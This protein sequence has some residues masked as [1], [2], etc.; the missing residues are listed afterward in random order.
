MKKKLLIALLVFLGLVLLVAAGV[1][2][3]ILAGWIDNPFAEEEQEEGSVG[4]LRAPDTGEEPVFEMALP[5]GQ[6][7]SVRFDPS[8]GTPAWINGPFD[9]PAGV[10]PKDAAYAFFEKN[11]DIYGMT[12]PAEEL[13]LLSEGKDELGMSHVSLSQQYKGIPVFGSEL[14]VHVSAAN[15]IMAVNGS[16]FPNIDLSVEPTIDSGA[17]VEAA[18]R[19][20]EGVNL[21]KREGEEPQLVVVS[22]VGREAALSWKMTLLAEDSPAILVVFVDAHS[23]EVVFQYDDVKSVVKILSAENGSCD[24]SLDNL[25]MVYQSGQSDPPKNDIERD[26]FQNMEKVYQYFNNTH[27][28]NSY[29]GNGASVEAVVNCTFSGGPNAVWSGTEKKFIYDNG[30]R[31]G[32]KIAYGQSLDIVAH[33][34]T[35]AVTENT[36]G[37][38]YIFQSGA[39][40]ESYSDVFAAM[41]DRDDWE[42]GEDTGEVM[43]SMS[44]PAQHSQPAHMKDLNY[45]KAAECFNYKVILGFTRNDW[46]GVHSNS[47]IPNKAAYLTVTKLEEKGKKLNDT[48]YGRKVVEKIWYRALTSYLTPSSQFHD[49]RSASEVAAID[50]YGEGSDELKAVEE[51][52]SEVGIGTKGPT[53]NWARIKIKHDSPTAWFGMEKKVKVSVGVG[54]PS[55]PDWSTE[56]ASGNKGVFTEDGVY[57]DISEASDHLPPD[58]KHRWFL[59]VQDVK[60]DKKTASI[61][62]FGVIHDDLFYSTEDVPGTVTDK[63]ELTLFIPSK[64]KSGGGGTN[65]VKEETRAGAS[66]TVLVMDVSGSMSDYIGSGTKLDAAK[67]GASRII[68]MVRN[69]NVAQGG[70]H[71]LS[72]VSFHDTGQIEYDLGSRYD[73]L[74]SAIS[75]MSPQSGTNIGDGLQKGLSMVISSQTTR[76]RIIFLLSD[77]QSNTGMSNEEILSGPVETARKAGIKIYTIGFGESSQLD[78]EL[79]REIASQTG[80]EYFLTSS[81]Y[82]LDNIYINM[83]HKVSGEV[84]ASMAGEASGT[85]I[86]AG[87]FNI[88]VSKGELHGTI[89]WEEGKPSMKLIDPEGREV[90]SNYPGAVIFEDARPAYVVVK[91]PLP[92]NWKAMVESEE[93]GG[94]Y[95]IVVSAQEGSRRLEEYPIALVVATGASLLV[96]LAAF[97]IFRWPIRLG[98]KTEDQAPPACLG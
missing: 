73:S 35:H 40:N 38:L 98:R 59:K 25:K 89:N 14:A 45:A 46:C 33:E 68:S 80:G 97:A 12:S 47:G 17:A 83:R 42:I 18:K 93:G 29:N 52:F 8:T 19:H 39:L 62:Y 84:V 21:V 56:V 27:K 78:E 20:N 24:G 85:A 28:R 94:T 6:Q 43:R 44:N 87:N 1:T 88:D 36:A 96:G 71:R 11:K 55:D 91:N 9:V 65:V 81:G 51:A 66:D 41:V 64:T 79:L 31:D 4:F 57:V 70:S 22:P 63:G 67:S 37:L 26:T 72:L 82:A 2:V 74:E 30:Q 50:L 15:K 32:K 92:G 76:E 13:V 23:G 69:E 3:G 75:N 10:A 90:D 49:A 95:D 16:Y 48:D 5:D 61:E 53:K 54:E 60:E 34:Y 7:A 86:E 77:G 58:E